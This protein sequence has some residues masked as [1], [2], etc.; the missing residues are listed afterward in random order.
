MSGYRASVGGQF[1]GGAGAAASHPIDIGAAIDASLAGASTLI[2]N[3]YI[4]KQASAKLELEKQQRETEAQRYQQQNQREVTRDADTKAFRTDQLSRQSEKDAADHEY[5]MGELQQRSRAEE[6]KAMGMGIKPGKTTISTQPKVA[7]SPVKALPI[8]QAFRQADLGTSSAPAQ[9]P[10][11]T[12]VQEGTFGS[13]PHLNV[14]STQDEY[15]PNADPRMLRQDAAIEG[16]L[17]VAKLRT[18]AQERIAGGHDA[19]RRDIASQVQAYKTGNGNKPITDAQRGAMVQRAFAHAMRPPES[20]SGGLGMTDKDAALEYARQ[21]V[22]KM[23][24][25]TGHVAAGDES[26]VSDADLWEQKVKGG[27]SKGAAT[28]YV[29]GRKK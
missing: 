24:G 21:A 5:R 20:L 26:K 12:P 11:T 10:L 13:I 29:K 22:E 8:A 25:A 15:D 17:D 14:T 4:R 7:P 2:Q 27:M 18:A 19:L 6:L 9:T 28:A 3:A 16:R 23:V 1:G